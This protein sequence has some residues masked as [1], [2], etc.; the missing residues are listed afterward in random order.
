MV[1]QFMSHKALTKIAQNHQIDSY[2]EHFI[3]PRGNC[4][5]GTIKGQRKQGKKK[6]KS[7]GKGGKPSLKTVNSAV[8]TWFD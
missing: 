7:M 5:K 2:S 6:L 1:S 8:E 3:N 4:E